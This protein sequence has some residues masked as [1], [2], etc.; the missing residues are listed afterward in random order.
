MIEL[1]RNFGCVINNERPKEKVEV[2]MVEVV[3][4]GDGGLVGGR[5]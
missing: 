2:G 3:G 4:S 5:G 1:A